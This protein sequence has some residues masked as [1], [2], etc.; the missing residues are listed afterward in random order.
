MQSQTIDYM[1]AAYGPE[2]SAS[3]TGGNGF[4]RD[5]LAGIAAMYSAPFY[6]HFKSNT[7]EYPTTILGGIGVA[8]AIPVY[9]FYI[10]GPQ[11]RARSPYAQTLAA[12]DAGASSATEKSATA[13]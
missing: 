11:I 4:A 3:A 13:A 2:Y 6:E 12:A 1:V 7:L 8:V 10:Y 9:V 5:C